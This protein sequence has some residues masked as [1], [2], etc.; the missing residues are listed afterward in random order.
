MD[1]GR[2]SVVDRVDHEQRRTSVTAATT[3]KICRSNGSRRLPNSLAA[4]AGQ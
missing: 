3:R 4:Q 1:A 2:L